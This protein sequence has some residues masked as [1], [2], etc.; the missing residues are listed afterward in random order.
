VK[1]KE[2]KAEAEK[3]SGK[4]KRKRERERERGRRKEK[5]GERKRERKR[6]GFLRLLL[7]ASITVVNC[8]NGACTAQLYA[9]C[10]HCRVMRLSMG[11][12]SG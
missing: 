9:S 7:V 8:P 3:N 5:K 1:K 6:S 12:S 4:L 11:L 10:I 2:R